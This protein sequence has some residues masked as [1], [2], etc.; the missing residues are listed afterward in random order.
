[1]K[2]Y[3]FYF[4]YILKCLLD[5]F[6]IFLEAIIIV[7]VNLG[8]IFPSFPVVLSLYK[9]LLS[10]RLAVP[11]SKVYSSLNFIELNISWISGEFTFAKNTL[12]KLGRKRNFNL[13]ANQFI[14][15]DIL[16]VELLN[17]VK[18]YLFFLKKTFFYIEDIY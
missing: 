10:T 8:I 6:L 3:Y 9:G 14:R 11:S 17:I 12:S 18:L 15:I 4:L 7:L 1:M 2:V 16:L 5:S 13:I